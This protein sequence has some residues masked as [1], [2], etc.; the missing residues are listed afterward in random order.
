MGWILDKHNPDL[1]SG[2]IA[3][4]CFEEY[5]TYARD[6]GFE[7]NQIR[8]LAKEIKPGDFIWARV[9]G[10]Y[11]IAKVAENSR[12]SYN[13]SDEAM[14]YR[15]CNELSN[16]YWKPVG[17]RKDVDS[18]ILERMER[19][20]TLCRMFDSNNPNFNFG[21]KYSQ[22]IFDRIGEKKTALYGAIL[23]D[24]VGVPY[25]F[26]RRTVDDINFPLFCNE[27]QFSDDT[28]TTIAIAD[29]ILKS[30]KS[31]EETFQNELINSLQTWCRRYPNSGYGRRFHDWINS[32]NPKPYNSY[33][34][35]AAMRVSAAGW[36]Y[37]TIFDTR[38]AARNTACITHNH[39]EGIKGAMAAASAIFL[40]RNGKSKSEIKNYIASE[41]GYNLDR[42]IEE[43]R[44]NYTH[45]EKI[46]KTVPEA[47]IAF[48]ESENFEGALRKSIY[49]GGDTDTLGAIAGSIAEAFY[50]IPDNLMKGASQTRDFRRELDASFS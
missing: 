7:P 45:T 9:D 6:E 40:A 34:N 31:D 48:L 8:Q 22:E 14:Y 10:K 33:G 28:V 21:L 23:G 19:G 5:E 15:A 27:S 20:Q 16:I 17:E 44:P 4:T 38:E 49:L 43:I 42:T 30:G 3:I 2:K 50:G 37:D 11:Y 24:I 18:R 47:I 25:E 29:A 32:D 36:F 1:A 26:D 41:F 46:W 39:P 35:G 12:Y 13:V